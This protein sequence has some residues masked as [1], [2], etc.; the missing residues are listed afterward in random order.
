MTRITVKAETGDKVRLKA[1]RHAGSRGIIEATR[2]G[3][4]VVQL[5]DSSQ[6]VLVVP[7]EVT[8]LSLA[9]RKAWVSMPDRHVGRPK[10]MR[11]CDRVSVTLRIDRDLWEQFRSKE[12]I[13]LIDDRTATINSWLREK[14]AELERVERQ[15]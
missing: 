10:G 14:L 12:A 8:N 15:S 7:E 13:G 6:K 4:L 2:D 9:A 3:K 5:E 1:K 11:F